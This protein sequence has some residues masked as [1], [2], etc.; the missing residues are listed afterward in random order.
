MDI[1]ENFDNIKREISEACGKVDRSPEDIKVIA[2]TK[3]VTDERVEQAIEG[4]KNILI[5]NGI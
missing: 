1:R 5:K 4:N 3:Y 2:V